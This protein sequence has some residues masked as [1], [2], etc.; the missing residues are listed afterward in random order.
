MYL[1]VFLSILGIRGFP[2]APCLGFWA[3]NLNVLGSNPAF[4]VYT[5]IRQNYFGY[6]LSAFPTQDFN[7]NL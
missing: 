1:N 2:M 6:L 3:A 4:T 7:N 5:P